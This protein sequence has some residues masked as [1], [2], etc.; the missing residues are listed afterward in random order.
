MR[1][2]QDLRNQYRIELMGPFL[3]L[4]WKLEELL[5]EGKSR[6]WRGQAERDSPLFANH[7]ALV[8]TN[9]FGEGSAELSAFVDALLLQVAVPL[10]VG[11]TVW[12]RG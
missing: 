2:I 6:N 11:G 7:T 12:V 5:R 3:S 8:L 4:A 10:G 9:G 1:H